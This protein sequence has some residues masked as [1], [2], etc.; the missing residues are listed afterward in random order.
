MDPY[1]LKRDNRK[2]FFDKEKLK[3]R[4]ATPSDRKYRILNKQE[5]S[6]T[7]IE[8]EL[9]L[10]GNDYRYHEDLSMTY[11]QDE[12]DSQQV[13][14]KLKEVL[15]KKVG[16]TDFGASERLTRKNLESMNVDQL[17][18]VLGRNKFKSERTELSDALPAKSV[19]QIKKAPAQSASA[20][21]SMIP[22]ELE[23]EQSFLDDL[24]S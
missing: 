1:S 5:Q 23:T 10:E 12:F 15:Q 22:E 13:N 16:D 14:R 20:T 19:P 9:S 4:H 21:T 24:I 8:E 11:G 18:K 6:T 2:K 7:E 3:R 17:N